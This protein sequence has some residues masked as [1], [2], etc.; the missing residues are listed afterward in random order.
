MKT[1]ESKVKAGE[2]KVKTG[3]RKV[4]EHVKDGCGTSVL[5]RWDWIDLWVGLVKSP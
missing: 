2:S 5:Y 1:G 3:E 4:K